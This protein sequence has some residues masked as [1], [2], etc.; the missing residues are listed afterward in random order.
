M[1]FNHLKSIITAEDAESAELFTVTGAY[2]AS[3]NI[4]IF[5]AFSATSAVKILTLTDCYK[6]T[7]RSCPDW[8]A[9]ILSTISFNR[10]C[11]DC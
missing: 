10:R 9:C 8:Y 1:G 2:G 7:L 6:I 4:E 11:L 3:N 5:S